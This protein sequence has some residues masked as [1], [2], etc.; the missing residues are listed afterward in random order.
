MNGDGKI[1]GMLKKAIAWG[2]KEGTARPGNPEVGWRTQAGFACN[3][4]G[5]GVVSQ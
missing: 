4:F 3:F 1:T 2:K 5:C